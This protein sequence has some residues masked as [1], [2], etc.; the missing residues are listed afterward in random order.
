MESPDVAGGNSQNVGKK[1][2]QG[3]ISVSGLLRVSALIDRLT[4]VV[5]RTL[6]WLILATVLISTANAIARKFFDSSSN[7]WLELQ[8]YLFS[9]VFLGCAGYALLRKEHIRI[10][11]VASHLSKKANDRIALFGHVFFLLPLC[12]IMLYES[13]PYFLESWRI[14]EHSSNAGGLLR[15][16]VK[17]MIIVGFG[18]LLLQG[19]SEIIKQIGVMRG[20]YVDPRTRTQPH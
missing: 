7:A 19:I 11:I 10:D 8:W 20:V 16:P 15:W 18:L 14:D 6:Y 9:A 2:V 1:Q 5:G 3:V 12:L 13:W 4:E 17:L